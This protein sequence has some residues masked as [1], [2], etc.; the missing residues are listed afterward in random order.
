MDFIELTIEDVIGP[1]AFCEQSSNWLFFLSLGSNSQ[2]VGGHDKSHHTDEYYW[3]ERTHIEFFL[4]NNTVFKEG[5]TQFVGSHKELYKEILYQQLDA[6]KHRDYGFKIA[7]SIA[8]VF[9]KIKE[10]QHEWDK[11]SAEY[12]NF[13]LNKELISK[14][15]IK[16]KVMK[17]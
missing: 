2:K 3:C 17:C 15:N 13:E 11:L 9:T 16:K 1:N 8:F 10:N 5:L 14:D 7:S 4:K 6:N 12:N